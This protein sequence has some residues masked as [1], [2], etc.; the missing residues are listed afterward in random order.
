MPYFA[1]QMVF[2]VKFIFKW[3]KV[4]QVQKIMNSI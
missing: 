2:F 1:Q 4:M 3:E